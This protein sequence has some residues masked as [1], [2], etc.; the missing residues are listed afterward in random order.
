MIDDVQ[1]AEVYFEP[2]VNDEPKWD[3]QVTEL[4]D[5]NGLNGN[6]GSLAKGNF[7]KPRCTS[8]YACTDPPMPQIER[9]HDE[10]QCQDGM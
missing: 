7:A 1:V 6:F 9:E 10:Y 8:I 2:E 4:V 5:Q 3:Q